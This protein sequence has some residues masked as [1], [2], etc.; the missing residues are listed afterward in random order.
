MSGQT[1][2]DLLK[3]S[4]QFQISDGIAFS[5]ADA[6]GNFV[7]VPELAQ[8]GSL[9]ITFQGLGKS[10]H[11][12]NAGVYAGQFF[13]TY[14]GKITP[15]AFDTL[16]ICYDTTVATASVIILDMDSDE[17]WTVRAFD[18]RGTDIRTIVLDSSIPPVE[19]GA[20]L[21]SVSFGLG[22]PYRFYQRRF[23]AIVRP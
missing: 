17:Q 6:L 12:L 11:D 3:I 13:L 8:V 22:Y 15:A 19:F 5:V 2:T 1:S 10:N 14:T 7:I 4:I 21:W 20:T 9:R 23:T 16:Q 18:P